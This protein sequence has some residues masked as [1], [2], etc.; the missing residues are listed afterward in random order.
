MRVCA[1]CDQ[2]LRKG[3]KTVEHALPLWLMKA[4]GITDQ[5]LS[6][7][8]WRPTAIGETGP[9][10]PRA[11]V[12]G[13]HHA[14]PSFVSGGICANCNNGWMSDLENRAKPILT[15]LFDG[16]PPADL[17]P[18]ERALLARWAIKTAFMLDSPS[19]Y[20]KRVP[21]S[22]FHEFYESIAGEIPPHLVVVAGTHAETSQFNW[23][24]SAM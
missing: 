18:E 24:I 9:I 15:Q 13:R 5:V 2:E 21:A 22:H 3:T 11:F 17:N 23:A 10:P 16:M 4:L 19:L 7:I 6:R 20:R 8:H 12:K 1:F 14:M